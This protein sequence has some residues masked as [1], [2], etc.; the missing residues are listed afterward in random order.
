LTLPGACDRSLVTILAPARDR[1]TAMH[2]DYDGE[3]S[4]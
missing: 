3:A 1:E 2:R 4:I